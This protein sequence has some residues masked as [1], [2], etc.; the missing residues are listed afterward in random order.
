MIRMREASSSDHACTFASALATSAAKSARRSS[1]PGGSGPCIEW[2]A[3]IPQHPVSNLDGCTHG[4][5]NAAFA[6]PAYLLTAGG[7]RVIVDAYGP[8]GAQDQGG[9]VAPLRLPSSPGKETSAPA[10]A[11]AATIVAV[12]SAS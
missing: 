12:L 5:P 2:T 4:R 3:S 6:V 8:P 1:V 11:Q 7:L 10:S 9:D